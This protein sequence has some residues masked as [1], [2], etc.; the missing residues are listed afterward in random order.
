MVSCMLTWIHNHQEF[1]GSF[2]GGAW[3]VL[4]LQRLLQRAQPDTELSER[5]LP[6]LE[7]AMFRC[8]DERRWFSLPSLAEGGPPLR[9]TGE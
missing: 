6:T 2:A 3:L 8:F 5:H 4:C 7:S 9:Q 1:G